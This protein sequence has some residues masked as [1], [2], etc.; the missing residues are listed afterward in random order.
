[1]D[2]DLLV[3]KTLQRAKLWEV[4]TPQCIRPDLLRAGFELVRRQGLE[5]TDD[6]SIVEALGRPVKITAGAYTNIK[7]G[8][9]AAPRPGLLAGAGAAG[10]G[11]GRGWGW[12]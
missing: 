1:V 8:R 5:V 6:V 11:W 12:G 9:A 10:W 7:V 3:V 2:G 4:Q